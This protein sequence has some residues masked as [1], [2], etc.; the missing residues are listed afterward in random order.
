MRILLTGAGGF[1]GWHTRVRLAA[2]G[3]HEVVPVYRQDWGSLASSVRDVDAIV[4][5]AGVN[6]GPADELCD[7]NIALARALVDAVAQSRRRPRIVFANSVQAGNNTPYGQGKERASQLLAETAERNGLNYVDVLLPNLFGEHG[8]PNYNSFVH[9]FVSAVITGTIPQVDDRQIALLHVQQA[10]QSLMGALEVNGQLAV[11]PTGLQVS[12][13]KVLDKLRDFHQLY[14]V[15]DIP[16]L[17]SDF[18]LDMFNT[19]RASLFPHHYPIRL[20]PRTDHRGSLLEVVRAHGG[21]GQTFVSTTYPG[22]TRGEHFHLRKVERFV[23]LTGRARISL[24]RMYHDKVVSFDVDGERP[25]I[26][27]MPTMWAHNIT[28]VGNSDLTTLFWT[29][30]VFDPAKPDTYSE[31]VE[32]SDA[33]TSRVR[34]ANHSATDAGRH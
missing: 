33:E 32:S 25:A 14:A 31:S 13:R 23:V 17:E 20:L 24:R 26:V 3:G 6:R 19:F 9:T 22:I 4:H 5:V 28:N 34:S 8:R 2:L 12:V 29:Q 10:A 11:A 27:D 1:L 7:G 18:D 21:P 15:G 16:P 30:E